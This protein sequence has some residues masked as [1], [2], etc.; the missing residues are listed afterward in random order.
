MSIVAWEELQR[1]LL[2]S[3]EWL[4]QLYKLFKSTQFSK[5]VSSSCSLARQVVV[6]NASTTSS[7]LWIKDSGATN[8]MTKCSKLFSS[9]PCA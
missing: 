2:F 6:F 1:H 9:S 7:C 3:K 5:N 8:H 4:D